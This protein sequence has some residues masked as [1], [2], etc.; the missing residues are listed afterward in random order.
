MGGSC[1][2]TSQKKQDKQNLFHYQ[3]IDVK[4][5]QMLCLIIK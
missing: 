3:N 2:E 5:Q 4:I 1:W